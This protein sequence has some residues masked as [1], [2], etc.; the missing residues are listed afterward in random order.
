MLPIAYLPCE[1]YP[2]G[3]NALAHGARSRGLLAVRSLQ[4]PGLPRYALGSLGAPLLI[5][6]AGE[7]LKLSELGRL[8]GLGSPWT[9]DAIGP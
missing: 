1:L 9:G 8:Y 6:V 3:H 4:A 2:F 7:C 5:A